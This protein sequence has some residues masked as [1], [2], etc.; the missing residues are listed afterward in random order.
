MADCRPG[1]GPSPTTG[2]WSWTRRG[3]E[4]RSAAVLGS[5]G[6]LPAKASSRQAANSKA[7]VDELVLVTPSDVPPGTAS[8]ELAYDA[9]FAP[10]LH[11]L[12]RVE[13]AG[14]SYAFTQFEP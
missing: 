10:G 11:G 13:E 9:P 4:I 2:A 1:Y 8:V 5:F 12:Y 14:K 6:A 3:L 7:E